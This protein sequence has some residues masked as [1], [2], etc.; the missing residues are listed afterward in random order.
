MRSKGMGMEASWQLLRYTPMS[1]V[2]FQRVCESCKQSIAY[3]YNWTHHHQHI[4]AFGRRFNKITDESTPCSYLKLQPGPLYPF[5]LRVRQKDQSARKVMV[6]VLVFV[7]C[8]KCSLTICVRRI[9][10]CSSRACIYMWIHPYVKAFSV[11]RPLKP[12]CQ[13]LWAMWICSFIY[14]YALSVYEE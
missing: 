10:P 13:R 5:R 9:T 6:R 3:T 7:G 14:A 4:Q 11:Y 1:M 2:T 8:V 12:F